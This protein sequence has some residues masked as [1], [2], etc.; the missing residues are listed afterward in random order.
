MA[1]GDQPESKKPAKLGVANYSMLSKAATAGSGPKKLTT[2][3]IDAGLKAIQAG[4]NSVRVGGQTLT[5]SGF[6]NMLSDVVSPTAL[7]KIRTGEIVTKMKPPTSSGRLQV[8]FASKGMVVGQRA[9]PAKVN[10]INK[11]KGHTDFR[12]GGLFKR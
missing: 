6:L 10:K 4:R 1:L 9:K 7:R 12:K 3:V 8:S 5:K 2:D 11:K